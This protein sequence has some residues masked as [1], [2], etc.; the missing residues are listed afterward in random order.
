MKPYFH[1]MEGAYILPDTYRIYFSGSVDPAINL[2]LEEYLIKNAASDETIM[3]LWQSANTVVIGRNQNPYK[4]CDI[5][6][7][8]DDDV[9]LVRRLSG[10]GAVYQDL[11]NLNFTFIS[12]NESYSVENN[13][14]IILASLEMYD[15]KG[16]FN[17]KNDLL[18]EGRKFSG[19]AFTSDDKTSCHHGTLLVDTDLNRLAKYLSPSPLK[20][21]SNAVDSVVSRVRNLKEIS[22]KIT[23][24]E[25]KGSIVKSFNEF[26][27]SDAKPEY[28]DETSADLA[29]YTE[30]YRVKDWNF[31]QSPEFS[32]RLEKKFTWGI[33]EI[34][35]FIRD[36]IVRDFKFYTDSYISQDFSFLGRNLLDKP[37]DKK[38][39]MNEIQESVCDPLI[40]KDLCSLIEHS[41]MR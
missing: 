36:G 1:L 25:L 37:W 19:S 16:C 41:V 17:G 6:K 24:E 23:V 20:L 40:Q 7:L 4:E 29:D 13:F 5:Q 14:R 8:R 22:Q 28:I 27:H 34:N 38:I 2:S 10:G 39:V 18:Y 31:D 32:V 3:F 15:I 21:S 26:Y 9:R 35:I 30:K 12:S 11:G 33:C